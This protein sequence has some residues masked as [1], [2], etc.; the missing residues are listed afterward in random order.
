MGKGF[1]IEVIDESHGDCMSPIVLVPKANGACL[2]VNAASKCDA[3]LLFRIEDPGSD[4]NIPYITLSAYPL[5]MIQRILCCSST[6]YIYNTV[7]L[8]G[9]IIYRNNWRQHMQHV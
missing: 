6:V 1:K 2:H 8:Y 4:G 9:I 7:Y 5:G 3:K